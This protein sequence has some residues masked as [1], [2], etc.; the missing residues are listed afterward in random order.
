MPTSFSLSPAAPPQASISRSPVG[1]PAWK[2]PSKP[3][4]RSSS[5]AAAEEELR[6]F[7][8]D[9]DFHAGLPTGEREIDACG[10]AAGESENEV[11][12][13]FD[14]NLPEL[15]A[16]MAGSEFGRAEHPKKE[17]EEVD[18][19]I[20]ADATA[21]A[22][23]VGLPTFFVAG[24]RAVGENGVN[25]EDAAVFAGRE[26]LAE[27]LDIFEEAIVETDEDAAVG[28]FC[29]GDETLRLSAGA[30]ERL[31]DEDVRSERKNSWEE[32][33]GSVVGS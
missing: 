30:A 26:K 13:I 25:A 27:M 9:G 12:M 32:F 23:G 20:N 11:G 10:G 3:K 29:R 31:L 28:F 5:S 2:S 22:D 6:F 33:N 18:A 16:Q 7:G 24:L 14:L 15:A 19:R 21:A 8:F 17:I 4:K 1:N